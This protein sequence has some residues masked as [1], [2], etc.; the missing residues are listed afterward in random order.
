M[1]QCMGSALSFRR[2]HTDWDQNWDDSFWTNCYVW[3][4]IHITATCAS[5]V[6]FCDQYLEW[7]MMEFWKFIDKVLRVTRH[8][9]YSH[10]RFFSFNPFS[11][12]HNT[13]T[14]C[15]T[16]QRT[17]AY[18]HCNICAV[19]HSVQQITSENLLAQ[20]HLVRTTLEDF[21]VH[22]F[23]F[24]VGSIQFNLWTKQWWEP[25]WCLEARV[26]LKKSQV[27]F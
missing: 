22:F 11:A 16:L 15:N 6:F 17:A 24:W 4:D 19:T 13:E 7:F 25:I 21:F 9:Y 23:V 27:I 1:L 10:L 14:H 3:Q 20:N 2:R 12:L 18:T 26:T 8:T 5:R